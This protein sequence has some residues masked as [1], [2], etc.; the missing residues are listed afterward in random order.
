MIASHAGSRLQATGRQG[1]VL[2]EVDPTALDLQSDSFV[3][4]GVRLTVLAPG[5]RA[6][7]AEGAVERGG[8]ASAA[9]ALLA[10]LLAGLA[11]ES[12]AFTAAPRSPA[13]GSPPLRGLTLKVRAHQ[14]ATALV[15]IECPRDEDS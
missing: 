14:G 7:L 13:A 8:E 3:A 2:V 4:N 5:D 10:V 6:D 15:D 11:A 12:D 9:P 1:I